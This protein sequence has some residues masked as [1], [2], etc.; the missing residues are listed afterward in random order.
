[1]PN[2]EQES[3]LALILKNDDWYQQLLCEC[4][5]AE[6]HYLRI[7]AALSETDQ[8][9]LERYICLCEELESRR[10]YLTSQL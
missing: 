5:S 6:S 8:E 1:M 10:A 2:R 7:R 9:L 4:T 3:T